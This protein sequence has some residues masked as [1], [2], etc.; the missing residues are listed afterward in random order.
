[1]TDRA[2]V[3]GK[4]KD[5]GSLEPA[6]VKPCAFESGG[7]VRAMAV[8][9]VYYNPETL[10][11]EWASRPSIQIDDLTVS[12]GDLEKTTSGS[13][14]RK[15]LYDYDVDDNVIYKGWHTTHNAL[16]SDAGHYIMK[17][18]YS[19]AN[20]VKKQLA[21]GAWTNRSGLGW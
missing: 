6:N 13:Y 16:D 14:W 1:M 11:Y 20:V 5:T 8:V 17:F 12:M 9:P 18:T 10:S 3:F 15:T 2:L 4:D 19:G 7:E 21:V